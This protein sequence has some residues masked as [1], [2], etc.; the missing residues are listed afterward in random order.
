MKYVSDQNLRGIS[1]VSKREAKRHARFQSRQD[2]GGHFIG[3]I[4][5]SFPVFSVQRLS[6]TH[7]LLDRSPTAPQT[8][9]S[10]KQTPQNTRDYCVH[11]A[12]KKEVLR[13]LQVIHWVSHLVIICF[14]YSVCTWVASPSTPM[15][16]SPGS[17]TSIVFTALF[18]TRYPRTLQQSQ[19]SSIEGGSS[20]F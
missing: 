5:E 15:I 7:P 19:S 2:D 3:T 18:S 13:T 10:N 9:P 4:E 1:G 14:T 12:V 6:K 8:R 16:Q 17:V 11:V 20:G